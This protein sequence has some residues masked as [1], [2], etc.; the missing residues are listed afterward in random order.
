M[1]FNPYFAVTFGNEEEACAILPLTYDDV[2]GQIQ[3]CLDIVDNKI[4]DLLAPLEDGVGFD[5]IHENM[6]SHLKP[7]ARRDY[8]QELVKL[9]LVIK[10][11]LCKHHEFSYAR[12]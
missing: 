10:V 6:L 1:I 8:R 12:L 9:L 3:E 11:A 5:G 2:F 4:Y 7:Q